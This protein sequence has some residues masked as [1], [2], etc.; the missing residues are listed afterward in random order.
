MIHLALFVMLQQAVV[1]V[2]P[3]GGGNELLEV[4]NVYILP[5]GSGLD[6]YIANRLT[7]SGVLQVV[8]E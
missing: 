2:A 4:H 6:Q 7:R 1:P 5:M 3:A 8:T